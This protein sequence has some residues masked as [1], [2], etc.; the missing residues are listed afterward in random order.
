V[1]CKAVN[2]KS[3]DG[4]GADSGSFTGSFTFTIS[5]TGTLLMMHNCPAWYISPTTTGE[6]KWCP[7]G[8]MYSKETFGAKRSET[9]F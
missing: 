5:G 9:W 8:A 6:E 3:K 1:R 7:G 2:R 4:A